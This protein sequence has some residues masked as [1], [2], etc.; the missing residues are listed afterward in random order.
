M[1]RGTLH[2]DK[3]LDFMDWLDSKGYDFRSGLGEYQ[4][5]QVKVARNWIPIY[6]RSRGAH[7]TVQEGPLLRLVHNFCDE[8][9]PATGQGEEKCD[10]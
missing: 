7:L 5:L 1:K 2:R 4:V 6:D 10:T 9:K 3:I 8:R